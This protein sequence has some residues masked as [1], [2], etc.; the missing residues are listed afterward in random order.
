MDGIYLLSI[1][2]TNNMLEQ[3]ELY[4]SM[5]IISKNDY[6]NTI[7]EVSNKHKIEEQALYKQRSNFNLQKG[8]KNK[9]NL[10]YF[11]S[12][13]NNTCNN[14]IIW[15]FDFFKFSSHDSYAYYIA[16]FLATAY[17]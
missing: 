2:H 11:S 17:K 15:I 7:E 4:K 10:F 12:M 14:C 9:R 8:Y 5:D 16:V 1:N 3:D 6:L 13:G